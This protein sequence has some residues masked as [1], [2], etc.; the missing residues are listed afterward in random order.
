M[1]SCLNYVRRQLTKYFFLVEAPQT[2]KYVDETHTPYTL[3]SLFEATGYSGWVSGTR[4]SN[5]EPWLQIR[6]MLDKLT[7]IRRDVDMRNIFGFPPLARN[8]RSSGSGADPEA[9][10]DSIRPPTYVVDVPRSD[11]IVAEI[12]VSDISRIGTV[13]Y[14]TLKDQGETIVPVRFLDWV[15]V[16]YSNL[17]LVLN[18]SLESSAHLDEDLDVMVGEHTLTISPD[19]SDVVTVPVT[20]GAIV[21]REYRAP[22]RFVS[23]PD[24]LPFTL[25]VRPAVAYARLRFVE[26]MYFLW[27]P[28]L[29]VGV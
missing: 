25:P 23:L 28:D 7:L 1:E 10:W 4:R 17:T 12:R 21:D 15:Y 14:V 11:Y 26:P 2:N 3:A 24:D 13:Y 18:C 16:D 20:S 8:K 6:K 22:V 5:V 29:T 9:V 19:M 27:R